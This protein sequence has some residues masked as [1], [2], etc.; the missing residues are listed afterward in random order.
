MKNLFDFNHPFYRPLWIRI[1]IVTIASAWGLF[2]FLTGSIL[3]G[4]VFCGLA[5]AAFH[6]LF[7]AFDPRQ[8]ENDTNREEDPGA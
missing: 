8:A 4:V 7:M 3:W 6:G 5:A 2:E 1:T